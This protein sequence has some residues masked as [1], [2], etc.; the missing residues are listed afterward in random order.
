MLW[1]NL[2]ILKL[3]TI[4]PGFNEN[5]LLKIIKNFIKVLKNNLEQLFSGLA[6]ISSH[7]IVVSIMIIAYAFVGVFFF[8]GKLENRCRITPFPINGSWL[9]NP[10]VLDLCGEDICP[11]G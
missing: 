4:F 2:R 3:I 9:I 11:S 1:E 8:Q 5:F 6:K 7:L 10:N